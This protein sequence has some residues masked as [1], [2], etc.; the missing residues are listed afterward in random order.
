MQ[1]TF[2]SQLHYQTDNFSV[3]ARDLFNWVLNKLQSMSVMFNKFPIMCRPGSTIRMLNN[4]R[5]YS[6][7]ETHSSSREGSVQQWDTNL[8]P[9]LPEE[10]K[11]ISNRQIAVSSKSSVSLIML[12]LFVKCTQIG[13]KS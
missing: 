4:K 6:V 7:I 3:L 10:F 5:S 11:K 2:K 8:F 13:T 9:T 1:Y 12:L